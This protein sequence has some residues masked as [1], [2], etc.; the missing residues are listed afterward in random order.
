ML[1]GLLEHLVGEF[2]GALQLDLSLNN[3]TLF[4]YLLQLSHVKV[5]LQLSQLRGDLLWPSQSPAK[6]RA[7]IF[8]LLTVANS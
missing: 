8:Q 1:I 3:S 5:N 2:C 7:P 6:L 4:H